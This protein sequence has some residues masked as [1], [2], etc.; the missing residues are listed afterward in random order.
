M[1]RDA[2]EG[3]GERVRIAGGIAAIWSH[4]PEHTGGMTLECSDGTEAFLCFSCLERLPPD[5]IESDITA[6]A[7]ESD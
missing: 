6:L 4:T 7:T 2:C 5:P 1:G 3:C